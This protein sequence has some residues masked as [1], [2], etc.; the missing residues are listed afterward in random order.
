VEGEIEEGDRPWSR[1]D[2]DGCGIL[3]VDGEIGEVVGRGGAVGGWNHDAY[4]WK[5]RGGLGSLVEGTECDLEGGER[6][7]EASAVCFDDGL[8][9]GPAAE[10][11]GAALRGIGE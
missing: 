9:A 1:R 8:F 3:L 2:G 6:E 5:A 10:E 7:G 4:A 11:E